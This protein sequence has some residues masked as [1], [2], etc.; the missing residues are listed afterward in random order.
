MAGGTGPGCPD[1]TF[2]EYS[3]PARSITVVIELKDERY[4]ELIVEVEDPNFAV[5]LVQA[6][7]PHA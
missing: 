1:P 2:P 5:E 3:R 4:S 6:A 7:L